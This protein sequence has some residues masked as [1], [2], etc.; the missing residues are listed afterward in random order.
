LLFDGKLIVADP[1]DVQVSLSRS[2]ENERELAC[3]ANGGDPSKC[4]H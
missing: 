2:A 1:V 4:G 3:L